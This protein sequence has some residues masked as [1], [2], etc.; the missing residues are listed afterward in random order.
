MHEAER[1]AEPILF[2][3]EASVLSCIEER[4]SA[5]FEFEPVAELGQMRER[6]STAR[7]AEESNWAAPRLCAHPEKGC[8]RR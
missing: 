3:T 2:T 1:A 8:P 4:D 7:R 6:P 5:M